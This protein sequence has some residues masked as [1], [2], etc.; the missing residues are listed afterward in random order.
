MGK[1]A[2]FWVGAAR[3]EVGPQRVGGRGGEVA[4]RK[5]PPL[6]R[7]EEGGE[8]RRRS[9]RQRSRWEAQA[10]KTTPSS[11][12]RSYTCARGSGRGAAVRGLT[13]GPRL[14]MRRHRPRR[15]EDHPA[16]DGGHG[17]ERLGVVLMYCL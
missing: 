2:G 9:R 5:D 10:R 11:R 16:R 1:Q 13:R 3:A 14:S 4:G 6:Q 15:R 17:T 8:A 7:A 12:G